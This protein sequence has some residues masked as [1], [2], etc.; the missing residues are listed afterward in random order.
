MNKK[1]K[2]VGLQSNLKLVVSKI[3]GQFLGSASDIVNRTLSVIN[4]V[5]GSDSR[6]GFRDE[7]TGVGTLLGNVLVLDLDIPLMNSTINSSDED[8]FNRNV[9]RALVNEFGSVNVGYVSANPVTMRTV[10]VKV[11]TESEMPY[12]DI[13][14]ALKDIGTVTAV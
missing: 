11:Q 5:A 10:T 8:T 1:H 4:T 14:K 2:E 3:T 6:I 7:I 13:K 9:A 12:T